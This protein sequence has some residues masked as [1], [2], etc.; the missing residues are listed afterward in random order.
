[1]TTNEMDVAIHCFNGSGSARDNQ[2]GNFTTAIDN[3]T[4][5]GNAVIP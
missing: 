2:I 4:D 5:N 3:C 1:M